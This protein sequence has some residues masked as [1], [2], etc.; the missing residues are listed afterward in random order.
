MTGTEIRGKEPRKT[1]AC[2]AVVALVAL[3]GCVGGG[4]A[5][6]G[7]NI[8]PDVEPVDV[9]ETGDEILASSLNTVGEE[10]YT[11]ESRAGL[12]VASIFG[13]SISMNT[14][15]E[16]DENMS[17][18][19]TEG[20]EGVKFL[21]FSGGGGFNTTVYE[22]P[23]ARY[24][25]RSNDTTTGDWETTNADGPMSLS[26]E[27]V[28]AT[29]D[30]TEATVEGTEAVNGNETY[31]LSL[32]VPSDALGDA[33][34]RTMET[35]GADRI[36]D[37]SGGG[38]VSETDV[39]ESEAYLWVDRETDRPVRFAY[40]VSLGFEGDEEDEAGGEME[41]FSDTRY[42]YE[43]IEVEVPDEIDD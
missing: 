32:D 33:L 15:G 29:L 8:T 22:T 31:V 11:A 35:H 10:T 9:D 38:N 42:T 41:F 13:L 24:T 43:D 19:H 7:A 37:D 5:D 26:L 6:V 40:L 23:D 27:D 25:R 16:F 14:T 12:D 3:T 17:Y 36:G 20:E 28:S 21:V 39:N 1:I 18:A 30:D 4:E 34:S 2:V